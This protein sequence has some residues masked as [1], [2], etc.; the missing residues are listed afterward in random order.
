M[1][2][3]FERQKVSAFLRVWAL[4][5]KERLQIVRDPSSIIIAFVLPA[6]LLFL[7]GFGLTLDAKNIRFGIALEDQGW[8]ARDLA[9]AFT[10]SS[11]FQT[12]VV[13][14]RQELFP[15]VVAGEL[16]GVLVIPNGFSA[17]LYTPAFPDSA[18]APLQ[19]LTDGVLPNT[20]G[21]VQNY[22]LEV[23]SLWAG[24][25]SQNL[26]LEPRFWYNSEIESRY[27]IIPGIMA[28]IMALI[29]TMLTSLVVAREWE[30]G[31]ME[32]L[33]STPVSAFEILLGKLIPYYM[34]AMFSTF[35]SLAV[36]VGFFGIP[37]RGSL[38]MLFCVASL[39]M[40]S[41]LG[42]GL[43]IST[44]AKNQYVASFAALMSA[45]LPAVLLSGFVFEIESMPTFQRAVAAVL[46][47]RY[48][49]TCLKTL[50][51][52]GDVMGILLPNMLKLAAL[53]TLFLGVT[54]RHTPK[55]LD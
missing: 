24:L 30:Q 1:K 37:F 3:M 6:V 54:L 12:V 11:R 15:R 51:L 48:L 40:L 18:A 5:K 10:G 27:S 44:V 26:I 39:F 32:A 28:L 25:G 52:A 23:I 31:T 36:A 4:V 42:Q 41:S 47:A 7:F 19:L 45:F 46:P 2:T 17:A 13:P 50:F 20:A 55:R 38:L 29:G 9:M 34:L 53:G 21:M 33:L 14:A 43:I 8:A 22:S 49:V 35:F 16:K